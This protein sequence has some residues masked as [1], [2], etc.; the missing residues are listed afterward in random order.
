MGTGEDR[1]RRHPTPVTLLDERDQELIEALTLK[2]RLFSLEQIAR[3][4]WRESR[5][6]G[7]A[8]RR[9]GTLAA[10]GWLRRDAVTASREHYLHRPLFVWAPLEEEPHFGSLARL[11]AERFQGGPEEQRIVVRATEKAAALFGGH[12]G[13]LKTASIHHDI[14]LAGL[15]LHL[16]DNRCADAEAW[17]SEA[18]LA[19]ERRG[20]ILPDA[21]LA[22]ENGT[23]TK[24]IEYLGRYTPDRLRRLHEDC[25][26][27]AIPYELW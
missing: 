18:T 22:D 7:P 9:L 26:E 12:A 1:D 6:L 11:A 20:Q 8:A 13:S 19:A 5:G 27:R 14:Q 17:V 3:T 4:W 2:V 23:V 24:A 21:C 15:Y 25:S 10:A 16:R